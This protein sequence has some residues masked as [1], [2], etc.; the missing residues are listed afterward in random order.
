MDMIVLLSNEDIK[1]LRQSMQMNLR[2]FAVVAKVT[3]A[4]VCRW[5]SGDRRPHYDA[6]KRLN[7]LWRQAPRQLQTA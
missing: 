7:D 6:M 3:E 5:E 4:T 1:V 2:E